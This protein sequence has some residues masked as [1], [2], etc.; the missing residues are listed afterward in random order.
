MGSVVYGEYGDRSLRE[1]E[2]TSQTRS[3]ILPT[4]SIVV[5]RSSRSW[6]T[7]YI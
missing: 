5:L 6:F 1:R 4:L 7:F 3:M 2:M